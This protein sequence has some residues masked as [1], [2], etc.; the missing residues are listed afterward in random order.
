MCFYFSPPEMCNSLLHIHFVVCFGWLLTSSEHTPSDRLTESE[1]AGLRWHGVGLHICKAK[2]DSGLTDNVVAVLPAPGAPFCFWSAET[3]RSRRGTSPAGQRWLCAVLAQAAN[4]AAPSS[5][6][7]WVSSHLHHCTDNWVTWKVE[8]NS[9]ELCSKKMTRRT[10]LI[11]HVLA[12]VCLLA[13]AVFATLCLQS[14]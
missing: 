1:K 5:K 8:D 7:S 6:G 13:A 14:K 12:P 2:T 9:Q 11:G 10:W 4:D 3:A